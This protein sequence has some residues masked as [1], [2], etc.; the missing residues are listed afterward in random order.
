MKTTN[1][2]ALLYIL[3]TSYLLLSLPHNQI[4]FCLLSV[5]QIGQQDHLLK[6]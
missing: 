3:Y 4:I 5:K 6:R 1:Y 2:E